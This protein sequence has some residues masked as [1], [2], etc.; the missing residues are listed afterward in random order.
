MKPAI[1]VAALLFSGSVFA[2]CT[3]MD[4]W[5]WEEDSNQFGGGS[6]HTCG[7]YPADES[8]RVISYHTW[9][10]NYGTG[11]QTLLWRVLLAK[12]DRPQV[13]A[14]TNLRLWGGA[15]IDLDE[16]QIQDRFFIDKAN[17]PLNDT[18]NAFA[19]RADLGM[20]DYCQTL[21]RDQFVTLFV[22]QGDALK[23]VMKYLPLKQEL[24]T[25]GSP[26]SREGYSKTLKGEGRLE[27]LDTKT[28]GYRDLRLSTTAVLESYDEMAQES[29]DE[30][31]P[32]QWEE[33]FKRET[34]QFDTV[35]KFDG[36]RY[37]VQWEALPAKT[38]WQQ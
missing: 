8:L 9:A 16:E 6:L 12:A 17:Y 3:E 2:E 15:L 28:N 29:V 4:T 34:L 20:N 11:K 32:G 10:E 23:P 27:L 35:L 25:E 37:P 36:H 18:T 13:V 38:W 31:A 24:V 26:C 22:R 1:L 21:V 5:V 30:S 14:S 19:I 33:S 7:A